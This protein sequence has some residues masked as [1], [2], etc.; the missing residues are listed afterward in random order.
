MGGEDDFST[1]EGGVK[2]ID[3]TLWQPSVIG[4]KKVRWIFRCN[5]C[6]YSAFFLLWEGQ[7]MS[8]GCEKCTGDME[9]VN[10]VP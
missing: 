6:D 3:T 2:T 10:E 4:G 1:E 9:R 7:G 8:T 5:C